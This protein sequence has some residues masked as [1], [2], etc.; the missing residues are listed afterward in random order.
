M[1]LG[2]YA[3]WY[4]P[5]PGPA[6]LPG[7]YARALS[8]RGHDVRVLT[9]FPNYPTGRLYP[10]YTGRRALVETRDGIPVHRVPVYPNHGQSAVGRVANYVS[11]AM[12]ATLLGSNDLARADALWVYNSPA[13]VAL[14]LLLRRRRSRTPFL[15]HVQDLW[16]E[17]VVESGMLPTGAL[18]SMATSAIRAIVRHAEAAASAIAVISRSV[19]DLLVAKGLPREKIVYVPNPTDESLF[20]PRARRPEIRSQ[21]AASDDFVLMYAGSLGYVQALEVSVFAMELLKDRPDIKLVLVGSGIAEPSLRRLVARLGLKSVIFHGRTS[22]EQIPDLMAAADVQLVSLRDD[23]FLAATTPSKIQAIL[24]SR[25][26]ILAVLKGDGADL[27]IRSG[28]GL[29]CQPGDPGELAATIRRYADMPCADRALLGQS[30]RDYYGA[31]MSASQTAGAVE[32]LLVRIA[33]E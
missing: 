7:V 15:L 27:V 2:V 32:E 3:Q 29:V 9:G 1:R 31:H 8:E 11:F 25:T 17:S 26:P 20:Y 13:T 23:R 28:G 10:G 16:P 5:E 19:E 24:A 14:P 6:S 22:P 30:G 18:G 33:D 12:S 21:F 4:D